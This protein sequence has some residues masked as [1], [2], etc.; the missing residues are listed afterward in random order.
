M[1]RSNRRLGIV[2]VR[3]SESGEGSA[4][5]CPPTSK[6]PVQASHPAAQRPPASKSKPGRDQVPS[7]RP[8]VRRAASTK[9]EGPLFGTGSARCFDSG[10][11]EKQ[12]F[13]RWFLFFPFF[14]SRYTVHQEETKFP[15]TQSQSFTCLFHHT[16]T[17]FL[18]EPPKPPSMLFEALSVLVI[19]GLKLT[20]VGLAL[21]WIARY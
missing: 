20:A 3:K 11:K 5:M 10:Y 17:S 13:P 6:A 1:A 21:K 4:S 19:G 9:H 12:T 14:V 16:H 18:L 15:S 8:Y 7:S 2:R